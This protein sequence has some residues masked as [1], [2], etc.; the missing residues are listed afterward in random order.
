M[1]CRYAHAHDF[2]VGGGG[3]GGGG[4]D[5]YTRRINVILSRLLWWLIVANEL[6]F[7]LSS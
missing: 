2:A 3:G 5:M 4:K 1:M 6:D 7:Q